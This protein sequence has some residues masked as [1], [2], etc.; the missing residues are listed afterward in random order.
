MTMNFDVYDMLGFEIKI[1]DHVVGSFNFGNSATIRI[2]EVLEKKVIYP[3]S[4]GG[5]VPDPNLYLK[6]YWIHGR[7][8]PQK[9]SLI[10]IIP[11]EKSQ[12]LK[13]NIDAIK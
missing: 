5:I 2:G 9:P 13:V 12:L 6:I 10:S 1:G 8:R 3:K 11:G 7:G 4:Y